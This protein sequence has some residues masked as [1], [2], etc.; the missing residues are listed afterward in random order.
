MLGTTVDTSR[1]STSVY[2]ASGVSAVWN[3]PWAR[4][5]CSKVVDGLLSTGK[6]PQVAP[7]SGAMLAIVARS[8]S[9]SCRPGRAEELDELA[10]HAALA[11]HLGDGEHQVGGGGALGQLAGQA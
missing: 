9:D 4:M 10:D 6:M 8:A 5:Y 11:Q 7:Y 3:S 2:V 1:C